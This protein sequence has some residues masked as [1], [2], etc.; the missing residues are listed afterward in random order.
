V[1]DI[2]ADAHS[3]LASREDQMIE[4]LRE[5]LRIPSLES[6]AEPGAPFGPENRRA[7]DLMLD[8][9][10]AW[11]L[12]TK[13]VEGYCG[14]A[15][16]G[17]GPGLVVI[18][19]HLDVVPVG[20]GWQ[21]EPFGAEME[22]G[23]I[24][25][26]GASDDKG[27]TMASTYAALA[28]RD[29]KPDLGC[30]VRLVFGCNEE[31]G[32]GCIH[33]YVETEELPTFG[34]APDGGWPLIHAEKGISDFIVEADA[35]TGDFALLTLEGGQRPNIVIDHCRASVKVSAAIRAEVEDKISRRWDRNITLEWNGDVLEIE[36][37]GKAAH[38]SWPHGG[39]NAAIRT[40][41]FLTETAPLS[42]VQAYESLFE[43]PHIGGRGL[44][45][46]GADEPSGDLTANLGIISLANGRITMTINVRYPVT[47]KGEDIKAKAEAKLAKKE[48]N[49]R[50]VDF[51]DS[52]PLYFPLDHP[53]VAAIVES[54]KEE[55]GEDKE[56]GVMGGGTYARAIPNSVA[57]GTGWLGDGPAH[58]TDERMAVASL[59]KMS[60]I[61]ARVLHRLT[62]LAAEEAR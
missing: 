31:S 55:T 57:I 21:H 16:F 33:R 12:K 24:Y 25:A 27:P 44:G 42:S 13:D 28:L 15:E 47:W 17:E 51:S 6:P 41:R 43:I 50:L 10:R 11:G 36:A 60:R 49:C 4:D 2:V 48:G 23:Y 56:P 53:L 26:R 32:F 62:D 30:R 52:K 19:G 61:Y 3:W 38:G 46:T 58:E 37:V 1:P 54:Y 7:L 45:I 39:D 14:W 9:C 59:R 29:V 5:L 20:P 40:L 8:K 34:I 22:E 35:P 18:L